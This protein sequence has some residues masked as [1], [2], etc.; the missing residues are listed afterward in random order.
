LKEGGIISSL[1]EALWYEKTENKHVICRL[2]PH[3]CRI[4]PEKRGICGVRKNLDGMLVAENYG[5]AGAIAVDPIEKKPLYHFYPGTYVLSVGARGC[6]FKC[7]FCQNWE[8]AHGEPREVDVSPLGLINAVE[9]YR[10]YHDVVGIAYT[11]SEPLVW[12]EFVLDTSKLA[13]K[14]GL[15]NVLVTNG[16]IEE[17]PLK[18]LLY[19]I[20]AMNIDVKGFTDDF[21]RKIVRGDYRPVLRTAEIA[22]SQGCH[23]EITTLLIPGLNDSENEVKM[24]VDWIAEKLGKDTPLHFSRYFPNYELHLEPTPLETLK[25]AREIA[26]QKLL[27]V[28]LGNV[29]DREGAGT[30][31]PNCSS[32]IID[33]MGY[34]V[35]CSGL[36]DG[37]CALCGKKADIVTDL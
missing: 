21:Y 18:E 34:M 12:Y 31:C 36:V 28:Y 11:Y 6:N 20:D 13:K 8:L 32:L 22:K 16:F 1:K 27:Y 29:A 5:R 9:R 10:E 33:R 37:R 35:N 7:R 26:R 23:V 14:T 15:K 2:C 24:L 17:A 4:P 19:Y 25:K 3:N 30:Y